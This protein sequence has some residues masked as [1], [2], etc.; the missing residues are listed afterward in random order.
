M[1]DFLR[2]DA[3]LILLFI[4]NIVLLIWS[5]VSNVRI[6]NI[7]KNNKEFMR[8]LG[9]GKDFAE[10]L[11]RYMD[12][13]VNLERELGD[14]NIVCK[15]LDKRIKGCVQKV[16]IVRYNAYNDTTSNLS[17]ALAMLNEDNDG[18]VLNGIYSREMSNIYAKPIQN[19]KSSYTMT[20]EEQDAVFKAINI[21]E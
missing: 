19:G 15:S 12:K 6:K 16:G 5:I 7:R 2:T 14:T 11:T 8:K 1:L 21:N 18:V 20:Q 3:F 10:D 4:L 17:F 9:N 13:V